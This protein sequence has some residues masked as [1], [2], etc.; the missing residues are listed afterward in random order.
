LN[1][2]D[3]A[4]YLGTAQVDMQTVFGM[5]YIKNFLGLGDVFLNSSVPAGKFY[6]TAKENIIAYYIN[7]ASGDITFSQKESGFT[8]R[9][10]SIRAEYARMIDDYFTMFGYKTNRLK[11]P[12][13]NGRANWNYVKT[14]GCNIIGDIPQDDMQEIK[15][16]FNRGVTI[17]HHANTFLDYS[18]SNAIV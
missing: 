14:K 12:N 18:Q 1:P 4:D 16:M 13:I 3:V 7:V 6:A 17:W 15:T 10:M 2:L 5:N 8:W 11:V 9:K